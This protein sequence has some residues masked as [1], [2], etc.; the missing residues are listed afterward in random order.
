[1]N[2]KILTI[3]D[4]V[5]PALYDH[6]QAECFPDVELILSCGDL[7]PEYLSFLV[8]MFNVPLF[9]VKGNHDIRLDGYRPGGCINLDAKLVLHRGV[10]ILG[11][12]GSYWYN[13][14]PNQYTESQMRGKI[15]KMRM[16]IWWQKGVD[17]IITHAP[18]RHIHDGEDLCH[19]GFKCFRG[20][21]DRYAPSYFIHGHMHF[22]YT[23]DAQRMTKLNETK[24]INSYGHYI[25]EIDDSQRME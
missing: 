2:M 5:E 14:K 11:F 15:R 21:I 18:P 13:G 22:N 10:R 12:E 3:S 16:K 17:I 6:F 7:P 9:Y 23:H 25:F 8:T 1:M 20:L 4:L 19:K 24:V